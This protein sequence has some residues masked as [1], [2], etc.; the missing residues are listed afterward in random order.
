MLR[1]FWFSQLC[2]ER[3]K[4]KIKRKNSW[5]GSKKRKMTRA[6][7]KL[8][9]LEESEVSHRARITKQIDDYMLRHQNRLPFI[10]VLVWVGGENC[11][12]ISDIVMAL[13]LE[14]CAI[15][16]KAWGRKRVAEIKWKFII[17]P[18]FCMFL[19]GLL[20]VVDIECGYRWQRVG[21]GRETDRKTSIWRC[22]QQKYRRNFEFKDKW[23]T[24]FTLCV[25]R[26]CWP[27]LFFS[28]FP[29]IFNLIIV[30]A[31]DWNDLDFDSRREKTLIDKTLRRSRKTRFP[32]F[33]F[34]SQQFEAVAFRLF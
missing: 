19:W 20:R 1:P 29:L 26:S 7:K 28:T 15:R 33:Y 4:K 10:R 8:C 9:A 25:N 2:L 14:N 13:C 11:C 5:E 34:I 6:L 18:F 32:I 27:R 31:F 21:K 12:L 17:L 23:S 24:N 3:K 30:E 22:D 16:V